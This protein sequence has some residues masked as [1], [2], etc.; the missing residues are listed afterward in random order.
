M[1]STPTRCHALVLQHNKNRVRSL[2]KQS[3]SLSVFA[4]CLLRLSTMKVLILLALVAFA[5][6]FDFP[7]DWEAW[8]RVCLLPVLHVGAVYRKC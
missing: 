5:T 1:T 3:L 4:V 2:S 8:K 7:E 6:A